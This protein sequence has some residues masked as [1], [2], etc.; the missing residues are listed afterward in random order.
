[1]PRGFKDQPCAYCV[2][3]L[4]T[5]QGD[6]VFARQFFTEAE[7]G[8]L[9]K[10]PACV[11]CNNEKSRLEHYLASVL[12]FG[13]RHA[14]A[15]EALNRVGDRLAQNARLHRELEEG[16][17]DGAIP[18]RGE[19]FTDFM[20]FVVRGLLCYHWNV[21]LGNEHGV[22]V[23][24]P[25]VAAE[26]AFELFIR[27]SPRRRVDEN[28]GNG[29]VRYAGLQIADYEQLSL[30]KIWMYGGVQLSS[31][32]P[33]ATESSTSVIAMT[34]RNDFLARPAVAAIFG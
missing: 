21:R 24:N 4:S 29:T 20:G 23:I 26:E 13:G 28:L 10:V 31:G 5:R 14:D 34:A 33:D 16:A 6:H 17:Q 9:P 19:A 11:P 3:G 32:E 12:P 7:R 15:H 22:R 1:M 25:T 27:G 18:F 8:N 30:W 2:S